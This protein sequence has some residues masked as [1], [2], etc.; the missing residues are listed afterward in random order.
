MKKI[1]NILLLLPIV[2]LA[3]LDVSKIGGALS[4]IQSS[5][6]SKVLKFYNNSGLNLKKQ[7][8]F[9]SKSNADII[10]FPKKHNTH[11]A[12]VVNSYEALKSNQNS[13]GAI[14]MKKGRTQIIF[15][16]ERLENRG[17]NMMSSSKKYIV[18]EC[19]LSALCLLE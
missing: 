19:Q 2:A 17:L 13:I 11:Q 10:L 9:T 8:N 15:I 14:Y 16:K 6:S 5:K 18:P 7:L 1:I 3:D 4:S 12:L